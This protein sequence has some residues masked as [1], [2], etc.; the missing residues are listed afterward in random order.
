M[1]KL[2]GVIRNDVDKTNQTIKIDQS[3]CISTEGYIEKNTKSKNGIRTIV[4]PKEVFDLF[5]K[6]RKGQK[7][8]SDRIFNFRPDTFS[9]Q[10]AKDMKKIGL[11]DI[12]FHDLRHYHA[13]WLYKNGIPDLFAAQRLGDDLQTIKRIY[14]HI[15]D[16]FKD[17][18]NKEILDKISFL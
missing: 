4:A 3:L 8:L 2:R 13:T 5:E 1:S 14:Q 16:D 17:K 10:F 12:R 9:K 7:I 6:R 18:L 15:S 11:E